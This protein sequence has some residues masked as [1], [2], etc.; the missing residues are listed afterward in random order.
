MRPSGA[1]APA[2]VR[3]AAHPVRW[4]LLTELAV[5]DHRV[6]ELVPGVGRPQNV[7]SGTPGQGASS[8][9]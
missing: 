8:A 5:S 9:R 4:R 7:V 3:L 2:F 1:A 6:R